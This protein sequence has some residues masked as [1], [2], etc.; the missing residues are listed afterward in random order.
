MTIAVGTV[1]VDS[2]GNATGSGMALAIYTAVTAQFVSA[3]PSNATAASVV[4][5]KS[6]QAQLA[7]AIAQGV[8]AYLLANAVIG[9]GTFKD[10][11]S[12]NSII[13]VG[14]LT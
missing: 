9:P 1:A 8:A 4:A 11:I 10:S 3:L 5:W 13:G 14:T 6:G 12:N 2:S 7:I